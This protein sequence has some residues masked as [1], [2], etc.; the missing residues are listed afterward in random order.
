MA[1]IRTPE[2]V[3]LEQML[4]FSNIDLFEA[5][6]TKKYSDPLGAVYQGEV[7]CWHCL[8]KEDL[9]L[10]FTHPFFSSSAW[11][12]TPKCCKC[13][14]ILQVLLQHV[15][16]RFGLSRGQ[17]VFNKES[18]EAGEIIRWVEGDFAADYRYQV[19]CASDG[20][21]EIWHRDD[22]SLNIQGVDWK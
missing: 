20:A 3:A 1:T 14:A 6:D 5:P 2:T 11:S 15:D 12:F 13:L 22:M 4:L 10:G 8:M 17:V 7:Y 18:H 9:S 19:R 21:I 16:P